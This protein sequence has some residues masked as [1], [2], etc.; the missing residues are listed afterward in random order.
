LKK[1]ISKRLPKAS[2]PRTGELR[3]KTAPSKV[4]PRETVKLTAE[5]RRRLAAAKKKIDRLKQ[6]QRKLI[7]K[8]KAKQAREL[9]R[10]TDRTLKIAE[11]PVVGG[12]KRQSKMAANGTGSTGP[13][14]I[15]G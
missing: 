9:S 7:E 3:K 1:T 8:F 10:F 12:K 2:E 11:R 14:I 6:K 15:N 4:A 13:K 5:Q